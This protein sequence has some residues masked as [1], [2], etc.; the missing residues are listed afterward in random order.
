MQDEPAE[1][2]AF[3]R[4]Q[5][6][7]ITA[8]AVDGTYHVQIHWRPEL[9]HLA[10][11]FDDGGAALRYALTTAEKHGLIA[12]IAFRQPQEGAPPCS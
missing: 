8:E 12:A 2:I 4:R 6:G 10:R 1:V 11:D 3:F 7:W 9:Q 5:R